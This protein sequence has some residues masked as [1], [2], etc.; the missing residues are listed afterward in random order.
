MTMMG[1]DKYYTMVIPQSYLTVE[2]KALEI[3]VAKDFLA[4]LPSFSGE[5]EILAR[6]HL[7]QTY[8]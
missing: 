6:T 7:L 8:C 5:A 3:K 1:L 2:H 4:E